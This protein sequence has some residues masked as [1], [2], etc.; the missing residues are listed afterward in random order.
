MKRKDFEVPA[1]PI[2][3]REYAPQRWP[4]VA[5]DVA[6]PFRQA[7]ITGLLLALL[8]TG[9]VWGFLGNNLT[10]F[11]HISIIR[12]ATS[13]FATV[14]SI[15]VVFAWFWRLGVVTDTLWDIEEVIGLDINRDGSIGKPQPSMHL[16]IA[17]NNRTEFVDIEGLEGTQQLRTLAILGLTNRLNERSVKREF[18]WSREHWQTIRDRFIEREMVQWNGEPGSTQ[19]V[20]LTTKG[21]E[22]MHEILEQVT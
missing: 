4:S 20:R 8:F 7:V 5:S 9:V 19:G 21:H 18:D 22:V 13:T 15:S 1:S 16:E 14:F 12:G 17:Q 3:Q 10:E 2:H 6:V 11:L